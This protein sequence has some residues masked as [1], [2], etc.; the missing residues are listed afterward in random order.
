MGHFSLNISWRVRITLPRGLRSRFAFA[1][2]WP[3]GVGG[4]ALHMIDPK[5][6]PFGTFVSALAAA[7]EVSWRA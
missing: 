6:M 5:A 4:T 7:G 2:F 3:M 1:R